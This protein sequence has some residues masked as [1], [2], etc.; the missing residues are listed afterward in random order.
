MKTFLFYSSF[1]LM[2]IYSAALDGQEIFSEQSLNYSI[3]QEMEMKNFLTIR[4]IYDILQ[5]KNTTLEEVINLTPGIDWDE[6]EI[7]PHG[8]ESKEKITLHAVMK[9][10]WLRPMLKEL[11]YTAGEENMVLVTGVLESR[12]PTQ[13]E[14][15]SYLFKHIWVFDEDQLV[16][17]WE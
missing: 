17:F 16:F 10:K 2:F 5:N 4:E 8:F 12:Q 13:C 3:E 14:Y 11:E 6:V 15:I 9:N 1:F 7:L